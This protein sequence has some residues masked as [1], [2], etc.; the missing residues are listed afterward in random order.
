[1]P[2]G[3]IRDDEAD[4]TLRCSCT[5]SLVSSSIGPPATRPFDRNAELP[6][7]KETA[8]IVGRRG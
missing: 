8:A 2:A 4:R 1:V 5:T 3:D 6:D 7:I